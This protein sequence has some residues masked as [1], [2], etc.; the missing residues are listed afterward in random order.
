MELM[1]HFQYSPHQIFSASFSFRQNRHNNIYLY[2]TFLAF[3]Y[4][5]NTKMDF[6][7]MR[8]EGG[9][10][11]NLALY[12]SDYRIQANRTIIRMAASIMSFCLDFGHQ[13]LTGW[14][15]YRIQC[16]VS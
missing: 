14:A 3:P 10:R 1:T 15:V 7:K 6:Q 2:S 11:I 4:G 12:T 5:E 9:N 13:G 16:I 8:R